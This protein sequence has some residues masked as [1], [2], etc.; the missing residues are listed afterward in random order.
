MHKSAGTPGHMDARDPSDGSAVSACACSAPAWRGQSILAGREPRP[1]RGAA[2]SI[3]YG[4]L[5][6]ICRPERERKS[7]M[8]AIMQEHPPQKPAFATSSRKRSDRKR[9]M[10]SSFAQKRHNLSALPPKQNT[11][12]NRGKQVKEP[13]SHRNTTPHTPHT[14]SPCPPHHYTSLPAYTF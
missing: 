4:S 12:T 7:S 10:S 13:N 14:S 5:C 11:R 3:R 6:G 8:S 9:P 2:T 1:K